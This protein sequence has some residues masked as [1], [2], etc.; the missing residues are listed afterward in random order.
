MLFTRTNTTITSRI[1]NNTHSMK[2]TRAIVIDDDQDTL[3]IF[4]EF[5]K[6]K[7]VEV[8][9]KAKNGLQAL[10][11]YKE[12]KPDIVL[13]DV[14]MPDYN[15]FFGLEKIK[16]FDSNSK[17][18][19][20][21]ADLTEK[22]AQRLNELGADEILYKPYEIDQVMKTINKLLESKEEPIIA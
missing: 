14:M 5:L 4:C 21:T 13:M 22:T 1:T 15:G 17:I 3:D 6:L 9:G 18:V 12:T 11:L 2:T 20:V 8:V 16:E 7:K 19:M 10:R